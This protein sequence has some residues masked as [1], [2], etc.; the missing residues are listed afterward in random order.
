MIVL[1]PSLP[2]GLTAN[3]AAVLAL[4]VGRRAGHLVGPDLPDAAGH[5]HP[6]ITTVP[7]P[8]LRADPDRLADLHR[9]AVALAP[10]LVVGF[11]ALA[12]APRSYAAYAARLARAHPDHIRYLGPALL[13]PAPLVVRLTGDLPLLR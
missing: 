13:G 8:V 5:P 12:Q 1:D 4:T 11:P 6:G 10:L 7:L 2:P 9:R 3:A